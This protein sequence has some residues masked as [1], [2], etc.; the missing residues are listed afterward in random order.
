MIRRYCAT[1]GDAKGAFMTEETKGK[2]RSYFPIAIIGF[3]MAVVA[4]MAE[5]FSGLGTRW[6]VWHYRTGFLIL[7]WAAY[8]GIAAMAVSLTGCILTRRAGKGS[9]L[10]LS[11]VGLLVGVIAVGIPWTFWHVARHVPAINDITTSTDNPPR[12][13]AIAPVREREGVFVEYKGPDVAAK[14]HAAYPDI[15]PLDLP[16]T[17]SDAY[18]LALIAAR[19]LGWEIVD[20]NPKEGRIEATD[21]T[22]WFGF[23]DDIVIRITPKATG[24]RIDVRSASRVGRS[25]LGTNAKRI[26]GYLKKVREE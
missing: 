23:K 4:G 25:D 8:G 11:L 22:F 3:I 10:L 9:G 17:P 15:L 16:A 21:T 1:R 6:G 19:S 14:Q 7:R 5:A 24:S 13:S 2:S 18:V 20:A 26:R 12:F